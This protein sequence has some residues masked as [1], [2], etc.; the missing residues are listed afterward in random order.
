MIPHSDPLLAEVEGIERQMCGCK[1]HQKGGWLWGLIDIEEP[2]NDNGGMQLA[3]SLIPHLLRKAGIESTSVEGCRQGTQLYIDYILQLPSRGSVHLAGLPDFVILEKVTKR[4]L[5][6]KANR[7]RA[8]GETQSKPLDKQDKTKTA[9]LAQAGIYGVGELAKMN[10]NNV[11]VLV[12]FKDKTA[13]VA[14]P[15]KESPE[16]PLSGSVG[17]ATYKFVERMDPMSLKEKSDLQH[18][19]RPLVSTMRW[20][21]FNED[22]CSFWIQNK[23]FTQLATNIQL[24][25]S[26]SIR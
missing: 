2:L 19:T 6:R 23:T 26:N 22:K 24:W 9:T 1:A 18:F 15:S 25:R 4:N 3:R 7:L 12:L 13:Q 16:F 8:V 5:L 14:V 11:A 17:E 21:P 10:K 20:I